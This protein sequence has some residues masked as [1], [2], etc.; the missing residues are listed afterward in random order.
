MKKELL[1]SLAEEQVSN[2]SKVTLLGVEVPPS[3]CLNLDFRAVFLT[4]H[5]IISLFHG[6]CYL[7]WNSESS[8][9]L[10]KIVSKLFLHCSS[11]FPGIFA[12][13]KKYG[14][15]RYHLQLVKYTL[16]FS[17]Y[18]N[19]FWQ[20]NTDVHN[21]VTT[22]TVRIRKISVI[23]PNS[24]KLLFSQSPTPSSVLRNHYSVICPPMWPYQTII[25]QESCN[26]SLFISIFI[27]YNAFE[28]YPCCCM[29][30]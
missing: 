26:T 17:V 20:M 3:K 8:K 13:F 11:S 30:Q 2:L 15:L 7:T 18:F 14:S 16:P 28:I 29:Y 23:P 4:R 6:V 1:L 27:K 10:L 19:E 5:T 25:L 22:A 12:T 9:F 24:L 21:Y